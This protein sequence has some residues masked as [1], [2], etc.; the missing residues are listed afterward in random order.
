[1]VG[2]PGFWQDFDQIFGQV[3]DQIFGQVFDQ[4]FG[5]GVDQ[6]LRGGTNHEYTVQYYPD[7]KNTV[8]ST[9][10]TETSTTPSYFEKKV[11][12]FF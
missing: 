7:R 4:V 9:I 2:V 12:T 10:R 3:F 8:Y 11:F 1:M 5:Q 6:V